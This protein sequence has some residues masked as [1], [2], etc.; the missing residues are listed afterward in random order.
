MVSTPVT[1][2]S[3]AEVWSSSITVPTLR[4]PPSPVRTGI[5]PP[6]AATH[7]G[8]CAEQGPDLIGLHDPLGPRARDDAAAD[9]C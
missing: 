4:R 7:D 5:P 3:K 6:P 8:A 9:I 1:A 2:A